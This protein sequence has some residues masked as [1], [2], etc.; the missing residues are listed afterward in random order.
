MLTPVQH[1]SC[2][3]ESVSE[4][5]G[6]GW[7][8]K[9]KKKDEKKRPRY[10]IGFIMCL[11]IS[12]PSVLAAAGPGTVRTMFIKIRCLGLLEPDTTKRGRTR[13]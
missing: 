8:A 12:C 1:A 10:K 13:I 2:T 6:R 7:H 9:S 3:R 11:L 5:K 4:E